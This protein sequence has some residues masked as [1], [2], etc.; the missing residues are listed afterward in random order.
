[1]DRDDF[2]RTSIPNENQL[3]NELLEFGYDSIGYDSVANK[4]GKS[5]ENIDFGQTW[6]ID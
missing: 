2:R 6:P 1:M 5:F 3:R 4:T